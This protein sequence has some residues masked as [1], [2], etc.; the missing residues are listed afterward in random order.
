VQA[1]SV[2]QFCLGLRHPSGTQC[3]FMLPSD[4]CGF[5]DVECPLWWE[6]GS[7]VYSYSR[8][9]PR[10]SFS[11]TSAAWL[12]TMF[13]SLRFETLNLGGQ[14]LHIY[15]PQAQDSPVIPPSTGYDNPCKSQSRSYIATDSQSASLSWCQAP[16]RDPRS[17][18]L[19]YEFVDVGYALWREDGSVAYS[20]QN[21]W[22][23][24][25]TNYVPTTSVM[26]GVKTRYSRLKR[27]KAVKNLSCH[28][29]LFL[30][31]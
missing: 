11:G 6:D 30:S 14:S 26:C 23:I 10:S 7:V 22:G 17:I 21:E 8:A 24:N 9:S 1:R 15:F 31:R 28:S 27:I 29:D 12:M 3:K 25:A 20:V 16:I 13:Y 4:N 5:I 19:F 18:F 2:G